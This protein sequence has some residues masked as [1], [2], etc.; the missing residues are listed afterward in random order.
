M[1]AAARV[2]ARIGARIGVCTV[3]HHVRR[4]TDSH[5]W[6]GVLRFRFTFDPDAL[7]RIYI[8]VLSAQQH[9]YNG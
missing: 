2:G 3:P 1:R 5:R 7:S 8:R 6:R 9:I 4:N